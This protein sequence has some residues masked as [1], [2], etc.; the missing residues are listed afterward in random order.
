MQRFKSEWRFC[1]LALIGKRLKPTQAIALAWLRITGSCAADNLHGPPDMSAIEPLMP[2][3]GPCPHRQSGHCKNTTIT[4]FCPLPNMWKLFQIIS[5]QQ[6]VLNRGLNM[7]PFFWGIQNKKIIQNHNNI[8]PK[9][10][11]QILIQIY[12]R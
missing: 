6:E 9:K 8:A 11:V 3:Q 1:T 12:C 4:F 2:L 5:F 7:L 10:Q